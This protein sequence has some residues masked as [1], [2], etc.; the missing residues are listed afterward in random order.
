MLC[1]KVLAP[2]FIQ[3]ATMLQIRGLPAIFAAFLRAP[4]PPP[5]GPPRTGARPLAEVKAQTIAIRIDQIKILCYSFKAAMN[6]F[7]SSLAYFIIEIN[8]P[9]AS[10]G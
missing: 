10:S 5:A 8:V 1:G 4:P 2:L 9:F 6:S 3:R 7:F